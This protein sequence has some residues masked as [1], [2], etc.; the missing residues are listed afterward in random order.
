MKLYLK[1][2]FSPEGASPMDTII[3]AEKAGFSPYIG[4]FDFVVDYDTLDEYK[5]IT[6]KI[7]EMLKGT[8]TIYKVSTRN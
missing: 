5:E 7:H 1:I 8:K 3:I 2:Y 4:D 6:K